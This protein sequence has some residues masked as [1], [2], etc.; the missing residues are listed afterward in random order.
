MLKRLRIKFICINMLIVTAML[1]VIFGMV[2]HF[3]RQ[4]LEAESLRTMQ[5]LAAEPLRHGRPDPRPGEARL[6]YFVLELGQRGDL[7]A[8][9]GGYYDLSDEK[10]LREILKAALETRGSAGI[11]P[12]YGLRFQRAAAP[13]GQR[14]IFVDISGEQNTLRDLARSC[15]LVGTPGLLAFFLI[16]L[17]LARWAV[18]PVERA[19]T[20]QRQFVADA[21]HELKTPLTVILTNAELMREQGG[22]ERARAQFSEGILSM[23]HQMRGLVEGLLELARVDSGTV[24]AAISPLDLSELVSDALLPFE[25]LYFEHDLEIRSAIERNIRVNGNAAQLR[26]AVE[27]LLDNA[28]KYSSA[29]SA[30]SVALKRRGRRCLLSVSNP[31]API[32]PE[33]LKKIFQRFYR[34]DTARSMNQSY[35]LGLSIAERIVK[36]HKGRIWAESRDGANTFYVELPIIMPQ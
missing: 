14:I 31:G 9:D 12:E 2:F 24:E 22:D 32:P 27:I 10:N 28:M 8:A 18:K 5:A 16:S 35:G 4:N 17:F 3:T 29:P 1:C 19:W 11:L 13:M 33:E 7:V 30:V 6:P 23:A 26:Q 25:P 20:E 36:K 21:S 15:A 34:M